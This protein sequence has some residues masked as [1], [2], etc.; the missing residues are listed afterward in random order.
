M[1][2]VTDITARCAEFDTQLERPEV[3]VFAAPGRDEAH[4]LSYASLRASDIG[5]SFIISEHPPGI[6]AREHWQ[7]TH[8]L[9]AR[10]TSEFVL[11]LE[12]DV[13]VNTHILHNI[14]TWR[15]KHDLKT[16][17]AGWLYAPGGYSRRDTWYAGSWDWYG[18]CGVLYRTSYLPF[19]IDA[20][21]TRMREMK[22]PWDLSIAWA[23]HLEGRRIRVHHPALVEHLNEL[24]SKMG[25]PVG[26]RRDSGG[27]FSQS[28]RRPERHEHGVVDQ[29][30]RKTI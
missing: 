30:G 4:A 13:L 24:P 8:E 20:A 12:D 6:S 5:E 17:S 10:A 23:C 14:A 11:V 27:T 9:A 16:F 29:W 18:T 28:W 25:N 15:Y 2:V 22:Q 3:V 1:A 7:A 19:L 21:W 26:G